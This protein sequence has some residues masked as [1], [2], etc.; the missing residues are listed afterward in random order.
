MTTDIIMLTRTWRRLWPKDTRALRVTRAAGEARITSVTHRAMPAPQFL[1]ASR[2]LSG[3]PA[4]SVRHFRNAAYFENHKQLK[5]S[6]K[7]VC[8]AKKLCRECGVMEGR[9]LECKKTVLFTVSEEVG[10]GA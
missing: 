7:T 3:S 10:V 8:E 5:I 4:T 6:G 9:G 2:T 1:P